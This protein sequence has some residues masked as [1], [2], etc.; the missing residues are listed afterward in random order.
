MI[1]R[2]LLFLEARAS[3]AAYICYRSVSYSMNESPDFA[4]ESVK[5]KTDAAFISLKLHSLRDI[6]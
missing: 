4:A 5:G 6:K 1:S 3:A 2:M